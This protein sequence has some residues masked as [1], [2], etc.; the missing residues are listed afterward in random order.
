MSLI[1]LDQ[2]RALLLAD[3]PPLGVE[4]VSLDE[5]L[6]RTLAVSVVASHTQPAEPRATMDGIAV[7]DAGP[8]AGTRWRL[9]GEI[10]AGVKMTAPLRPGDAVQIAT[11][12]VVPEGAIRVLPREIVQ[13]SESEVTLTS[14]A[15]PARFVRQSGADFKKGDCL[16]DR[17]VRIGPAELGLIAAANCAAVHVYCKPRVA[18]CSAGDE[19]IAPGSALHEGQSV[20]SATHALAALIRLWGG[21][22]HASFL[23]PDDLPSIVSALS[24]AAEQN[25]IVLCIGGAS[26]GARDLMRPA[27]NAIGAQ[28]LFGGIA[29]QPGKPCWHARGKGGG[30][31]LGLPGNPSSAFV[32]AHLLLLP[33]MEKLMERPSVRP[34]C[35]AYLTTS[36]SANGEREQYLRATATLDG[37]G[38]L[39]VTPLADQDSG[40]QANLARAQVLI[41]RPPDARSLDRGAKVEVLKLKNIR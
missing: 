9:I 22:P 40:L 27:A 29:V 6:G 39:L 25:D 17:G 23:L 3:L 12:A 30:L 26:V 37:E 21:L 2:A 28:L 19:L 13:F 33:L 24:T 36:L 14:D 18:V 35:P 11:G 38:R 41:R 4:G 8:V 5:A 15:G 34:L 7:P 10:P 16:L 32:C 20:D 31:I 1:N